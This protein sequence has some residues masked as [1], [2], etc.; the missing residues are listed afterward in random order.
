[1]LAQVTFDVELIAFK[2]L[3]TI[4]IAG[5]S[6][7]AM[8]RKNH[9]VIEGWLRKEGKFIVEHRDNEF[10]AKDIIEAGL[11]PRLVFWESGG[12]RCNTGSAQIICG[13]K[14]ERIAPVYIRR[15]GSLACSRHAKFIAWPGQKLV[16]V[17]VSH[18]RGDFIVRVDE[19]SFTESF[20]VEVERL[21]WGDELDKANIE[22]YLP[23]KIDRYL[24]AVKAA[25]N[26]ATCYHCREP[27]YI[28]DEE[29]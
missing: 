18:H 3:S 2:E 11:T 28:L 14:G 17:Y 25:M 29:S 24:E 20:H 22:E 15:R 27:H 10:T 7:P 21:W 9:S 8:V 19:V 1:M 13:L 23:T 4:K 26:K 16:V 12:G 5:K 6:F